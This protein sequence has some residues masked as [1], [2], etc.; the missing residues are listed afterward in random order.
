MIGVPL[1]S[2]CKPIAIIQHAWSKLQCHIYGHFYRPKMFTRGSMVQYT[3]ELC[4]EKTKWMNKEEHGW[5][6]I[7]KMPTWGDRGHD[8]QGYTFIG[9]PEGQSRTYHPGKK[10]KKHRKTK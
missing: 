1:R 8:S 6:Q 9:P 10:R 2:L 5:F 4:G 7:E 3:C